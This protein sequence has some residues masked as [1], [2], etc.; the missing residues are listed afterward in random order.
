MMDYECLIKQLYGFYK[1]TFVVVCFSNLYQDNYRFFRN[2]KAQHS[3]ADNGS[4][5]LDFHQP[6][7]TPSAPTFRE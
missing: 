6:S 4:L 2:K 1:V 5:G 7:P 3:K